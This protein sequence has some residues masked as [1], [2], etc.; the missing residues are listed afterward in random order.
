MRHYLQATV[1]SVLLAPTALSGGVPMRAAATPLVSSAG[2]S[3][4][5]TPTELCALGRAKHLATVATGTHPYIHT[6]A[7]T[8]VHPN[9]PLAH[10]RAS[11]TAL[12][13]TGEGG[14][15]D[16]AEALPKRCRDGEGPGL[17]VESWSRAF[18][19]LVAQKH[20]P[21]DGLIRMR[22]AAARQQLLIADRVREL[23]SGI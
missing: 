22:L 5:L 15:K 16:C 19:D 10:A 7:S 11:P 4:R 12:D 14:H 13:S 6:A 20:R 9:E 2:A 3:D 8:V 17:R 1:G 18:A 23:C 21:L